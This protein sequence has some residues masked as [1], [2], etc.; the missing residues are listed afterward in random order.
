MGF[1]L[2]NLVPPEEPEIRGADGKV[3]RGLV[4]PYSE[5]S[6]LKLTCSTYGGKPRPALTWWRDYTLLDD[7]FEYNDK[8][9]N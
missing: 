1:F 5:G 7:T 4:G 8:D 2:Q 3:L 6:P 9:G